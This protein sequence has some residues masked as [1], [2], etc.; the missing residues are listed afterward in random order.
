[1]P[2]SES[3]FTDEQIERL[4]TSFIKS[5]RRQGL[6]ATEEECCKLMEWATLAVVNYTGLMMCIDGHVEIQDF[7]NDDIQFVSAESIELHTPLMNQIMNQIEQ[8]FEEES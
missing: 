8:R 5:R 2:I 7:A 6:E 1:M 4:L 3:L